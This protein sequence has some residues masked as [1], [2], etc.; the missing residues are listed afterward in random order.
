VTSSSSLTC[1]P[2]RRHFVRFRLCHSLGRN[3]ASE[4]WI[5]WFSNDLSPCIRMGGRI[6]SQHIC[7]GGDCSSS[8]VDESNDRLVDD[9]V[10][11]SVCVLNIPRGGIGRHFSDRQCL[12][13]CSFCVK[14]PCRVDWNRRRF[15]TACKGSSF[16]PP[17]AHTESL[18]Y[19][20][21]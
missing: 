9:H 4:Q 20:R 19:G 5:V 15:S 11:Q 2:T 7:H 13:A 8:L 1:S 14:K 12:S 17:V 18:R 3:R 16:T 10:N 6:H 21:Y